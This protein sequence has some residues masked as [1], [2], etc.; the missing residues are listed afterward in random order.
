MWHIPPKAGN[1][2]YGS[3][4]DSRV[5][6]RRDIVV[7]TGILNPGCVGANLP[8]EFLRAVSKVEPQIRPHSWGG[9]QAPPLHFSFIKARPGNQ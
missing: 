7:P 5:L 8:F 6:L 9:A 2:P 3:L 4:N 1:R